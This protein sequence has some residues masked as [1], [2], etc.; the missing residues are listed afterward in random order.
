VWVCNKNS[1]DQRQSLECVV[2]GLVRELEKLAPHP[3][4]PA[5]VSLPHHPLLSKTADYDSTLGMLMAENFLASA[6]L[7]AANQN[8]VSSSASAFDSL[9]APALA[10]DWSNAIDAASEYLEERFTAP[11]EGQ[12]SF[13]RV[14]WASAKTLFNQEPELA[15]YRRDLP[16]RQKIEAALAH[17]LRKLDRLSV[18]S[19]APFPAPAAA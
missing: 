7:G 8:D 12:G 16:Q 2:S 6:F 1:R 5:P 13:A 19:P 3:A 10:L 11:G 18:T 9:G 17:Y 4:S 14:K 15:A